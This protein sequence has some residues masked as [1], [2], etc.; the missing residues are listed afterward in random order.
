M[1]VLKYI[2]LLSS[3]IPLT[4]CTSLNMPFFRLKLA[5]EIL[6]GDGYMP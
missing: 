1:F 4:T 5:A 6:R 3:E 2:E